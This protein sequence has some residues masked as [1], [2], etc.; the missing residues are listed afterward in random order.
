[1]EKA[2]LEE[3]VRIAEL[4]VDQERKAY[5]AQLKEAKGRITELS[6]SDKRL[7][8]QIRTYKT[9]LDS[10]SA[11]ECRRASK[12]LADHIERG[13][14]LAAKCSAELELEHAALTSC[15][16]A[17]EDIRSVYGGNQ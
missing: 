13:S 12:Q 14:A 11:E 17:Y 4:V 5:E 16:R 1:M 10:A 2:A 7:R 8:D 9:K 3:R 6:S 15:V